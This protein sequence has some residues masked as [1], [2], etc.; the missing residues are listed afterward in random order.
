MYGMPFE[1]VARYT[2]VGSA[3]R[4]VERIAAYA[5]AGVEEFVLTPLTGEPLHRFNAWPRFAR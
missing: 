1:R 4:V 3:E 5:A 2:P